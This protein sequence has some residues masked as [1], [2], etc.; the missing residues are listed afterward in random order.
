MNAFTG[1]NMLV[2]LRTI[3][4]GMARCQISDEPDQNLKT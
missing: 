3:L 1:D 2:I 4:D